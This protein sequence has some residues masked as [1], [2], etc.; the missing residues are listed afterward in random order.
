MQTLRIRKRVLMENKKY[1][2]SLIPKSFTSKTDEIGRRKLQQIGRVCVWAAAAAN[3]LAASYALLAQPVW[4]KVTA[5]ALS[6]LLLG[7]LICSLF[8][9]KVFFEPASESGTSPI[10]L[11]LDARVVPA[12][13]IL[14]SISSV[15]LLAR[16][17]ALAGINLTAFA[18]TTSAC[19]YI[20]WTTSRLALAKK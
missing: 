18:L 8:I 4:A 19:L 6:V 17:G 10:D 2:R 20:V 9:F 5:A 3:I 16:G 1:Q 11:R 13:T 7:M 14:A 12:L 15:L